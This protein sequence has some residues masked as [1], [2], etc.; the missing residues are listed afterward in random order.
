MKKSHNDTENDKNLKFS[1]F[2]RFYAFFSKFL[3]DF[4][5]WNGKTGQQGKNVLLVGFYEEF[6]VVSFTE[7]VSN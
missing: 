1:N 7:K 5:D 6:I 4:M 2:Q 3:T